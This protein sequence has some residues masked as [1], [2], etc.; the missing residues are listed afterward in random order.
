M[1]AISPYY[2]YHRLV[3]DV[4]LS[5]IFAHQL[6]KVSSASSVVLMRRVEINCHTVDMLGDRQ[7]HVL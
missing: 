2:H 4:P 7:S 3:P 1:G 6:L 5:I